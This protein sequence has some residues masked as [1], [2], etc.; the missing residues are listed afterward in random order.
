ME[1]G[2]VEMTVAMLRDEAARLAAENAA[3]R[4][5]TNELTVRCAA[6]GIT[7]SM[8]TMITAEEP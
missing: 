3:L 8:I 1:K 4:H 2:S 5:R 6:A 7:A